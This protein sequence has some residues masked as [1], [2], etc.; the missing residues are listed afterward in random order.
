MGNQY[1][2]EGKVSIPE[3]KR[4]IFNENVL[5]LLDYGGIRKL[6][7]M[8]IGKKAI[9]AARKPRPD[10]EGIVRFDYS[11]FE[12]QKRKESCYTM[13]MNCFRNCSTAAGMKRQKN[14]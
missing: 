6:K 12:N 13:H 3:E 2:L 5:K 14:F 8:E 1:W 11:V 10:G 4:D 9:T 7:E